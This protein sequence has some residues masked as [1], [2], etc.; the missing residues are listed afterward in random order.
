MQIVVFVHHLRATTQENLWYADWSVA[1]Q[2]FCRHPSSRHAATAGQDYVTC[3]R[4]RFTKPQQLWH[5]C[6]ASDLHQRAGTYGK[7]SSRSRGEMP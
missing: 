2:A 1:A 4:L 3:N 7:A 5:V 6:V